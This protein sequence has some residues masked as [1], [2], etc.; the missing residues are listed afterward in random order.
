M[1]S[2]CASGIRYQD[3]SS[4]PNGRELRIYVE[5]VL[6]PSDRRPKLRV[7]AHL[8]LR[9]RPGCLPCPPRRHPLLQVHALSPQ[10]RVPRREEDAAES[11]SLQHTIN[12][13]AVRYVYSV[14]VCGVGVR[15]VLDWGCRPDGFGFGGL[16][17]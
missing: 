2:L 6:N 14:R 13:R 3:A 15:A 8:V 11:A 4:L 10:S 5:Y 16:D 9:I 17:V 1:L 12:F 7:E